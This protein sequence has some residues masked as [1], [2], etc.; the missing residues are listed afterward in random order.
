[1]TGMVSRLPEKM[2]RKNRNEI[3]NVNLEGNFLWK[4]KQTNNAYGY[5][6]GC[7]QSQSNIHRYERPK[8][9]R[10]ISPFEYVVSLRSFHDIMCQVKIAR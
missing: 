4:R 7:D 6:G 9:V 1:M 5:S 10:D 3:P 8:A 2:L